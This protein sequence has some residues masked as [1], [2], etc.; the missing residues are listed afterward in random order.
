MRGNPPMR[1]LINRLI[2]WL[3][4]KGFDGDEITECIEYITKKD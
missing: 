3:K 4:S 1:V 2:Q